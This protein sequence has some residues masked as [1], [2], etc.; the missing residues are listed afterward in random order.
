M[1]DQELVR[2]IL[3]RLTRIE[4][5]TKAIDDLSHKTEKA[6]SM[7]LKNMEDIEELKETEQWLR[8]WV[9]GLFVAIIAFFLKQ[10][11]GG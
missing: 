3:Q 10:L 1:N 7:S 11:L 6:F 5:N 8:R 4:E 9:M 2:E